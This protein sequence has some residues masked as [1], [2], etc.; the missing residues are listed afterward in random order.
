M[1]T[2]T[3]DTPRDSVQSLD[4]LEHCV[5][6]AALADTDSLEA[7]NVR[8]RDRLSGRLASLFAAAQGYYTITRGPLTRDALAQILM[9]NEPDLDKHQ[10]YLGLYDVL[11]SPPYSTFTAEQ[12]RWHLH[13]YDLE[14]QV[15]QTGNIL[16]EAAEAMRSGVTAHGKFVTGSDAAWQVL[17]QRRLDFD[18][19]TSGGS[20]HEAEFTATTDHAKHD[21]QKAAELRASGLS[22]TFPLCVPEAQTLTDGLGPGDLHLVTAFAS[23]GKS[24]MMINDA[25][26]GWVQGKNVSLASGEMRV[27][28]NRCR[29]IALH[30]KWLFDR[31][32][33]EAPLETKKIQRG[34]LDQTEH[35]IFLQVL[36][37]IKTNPTYGKFH[38]FQF[39]FR[40][41]PSLIFNR[42]AAFDQIVPLD[43]GVVDYL[44]LMAS[45]RAR[46]QRREELDDLIRETKA[47]A[48][49]FAGGRGLAIEAG[50]QT[51]R[52][53]FEKA[54]QDGHYTLACF[55]ESSEAE[56]SA[57]T[58]TWLLSLQQNPEE[59]RAG[60]IKNRD[61]EL[62]EPFH[63]QRNLRYAQLTSLST[64]SAKATSSGA[65]LLTM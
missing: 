58:A 2:D 57:D 50:Y 9:Q 20:L 36:E 7:V 27:A 51:N 13:Q 56:K 43:L 35:E 48:L 21:Y 39:P 12:C 6:A 52:A 16:A 18:N 42:F 19:K 17:A 29:F 31:G 59:L 55:A 64:S 61:D 22:I 4:D 25:H 60:F 28:K 62:G 65:S 23:E 3:Q 44:G 38:T 24:F 54:R 34:L 53:S 11:T 40:A 5:V 8:Y 63:M 49:D 37:D 45:E 32:K 41:T 1:S 33:I 46:V 30:S 15:A 26:H 14:W 47:L 10:E